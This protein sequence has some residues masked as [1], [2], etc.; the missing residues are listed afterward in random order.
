M[1][2]RTIIHAPR[3]VENVTKVEKRAPT[4]ESVRLLREMEAAARA[5]VD[6]TIILRGNKF[7]AIAHAT[8]DA[9]SDCTLIRVMFSLNDHQMV[10]QYAHPRYRPNIE[11]GQ[12]VRRLIAEEVANAILGSVSNDIFRE[13]RA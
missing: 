12:N 8:W 11:I 4:D 2:D 6:K 10:V 13:L 9:M 3:V 5:E 7:E 1:F